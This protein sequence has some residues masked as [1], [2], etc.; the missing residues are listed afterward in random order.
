MHDLNPPSRSAD[1]SPTHIGIRIHT[2][3]DRRPGVLG[4]LLAQPN[5]GS[6]LYTIPGKGPVALAPGTPID[7]PAMTRPSTDELPR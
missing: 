2:I 3:S 6:G 5:L 1:L 4:L 7:G